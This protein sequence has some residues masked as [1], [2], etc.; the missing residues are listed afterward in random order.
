LIYV[1]Q[2][3]TP[4]VAY[5]V[6]DLADPGAAWKQLPLVGVDCR[7]GTPV[8]V[9]AA[10]ADANG[11]RVQDVDL[12]TGKVLT[13]PLPD[14]RG[15]VSTLTPDHDKL[16]FAPTPTWRGGYY[17]RK[18]HRFT[19]FPAT[20]AANGR[21]LIVAATDRA[22]VMWGLAHVTQKI[23]GAACSAPS[24]QNVGCDPIP[25]MTFER[26]EPKGVIISLAP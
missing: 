13:H 9:F 14:A 20:P 11:V 3:G 25:G 23:P 22:L 1:A 4:A 5:H 6:L 15:S 24:P 8:G 2:I 7:Y 16:V 10:F 21:Y 18:T 19:D 17:S 26:V 12:A